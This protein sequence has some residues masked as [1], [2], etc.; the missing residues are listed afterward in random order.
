MPLSH[1]PYSFIRQPRVHAVPCFRIKK[2]I[3]GSDPSKDNFN[4]GLMVV[5][6]PAPQDADAIAAGHGDIQQGWET[7]EE[8]VLNEVFRG[9]WE[10]LGPRYNASKRCFK[11]APGLWDTEAPDMAVVHYVGGK[12]WQPV[13]RDWEDNGPYE[14]L[15]GLWWD[16]RRQRILTGPN[17]E[18]PGLSL[19]PLIPLPANCKT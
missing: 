1:P 10:P 6:S 19:A 13:P 18:A 8:K 2:R 17:G 3:Y 14:A 4:A 9:R 7:N 5:V 16:I 11:H 12:P 15:F